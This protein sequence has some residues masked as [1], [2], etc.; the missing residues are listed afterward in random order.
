[1]DLPEYCIDGHDDAKD[2]KDQ[3]SAVGDAV[4]HDGSDS[5]NHA[6]EGP[7]TRQRRC[8]GQRTDVVRLYFCY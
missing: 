7:L 8:H 3:E 4:E 1:M 5:G 6:V 2:A